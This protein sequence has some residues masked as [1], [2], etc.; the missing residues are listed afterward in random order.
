[1]AEELA[2]LALYDDVVE[3]FATESPTVKIDFGWKAPAKQVNQGEGG[4]SRVV[5]V[6]GAEGKIGQ[7]NGARRA[8]R[9]PRPL[10]TLVER[11]TVYVW[12][13]DGSDPH[14]D[15]TQYR[16]AKLLHNAVVRAIQLSM[17]SGSLANL[18]ASGVAFEEPTWILSK[19][20]RRFG[21]ELKF[22]VNVEEMIPDVAYDEVSNA[23]ATIGAYL[24]D[25]LDS[26]DVLQG[27]P[28]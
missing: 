7:Y 10:A 2:C 1:M 5:F 16:A 23:Q 17:R 26:S 4:A 27:E 25:E 15:R 21:A 6:P 28:S 24:N 19:V 20:E 14:D 11:L 13:F 18:P 3:R 12:A 8:G 9:N 22:G